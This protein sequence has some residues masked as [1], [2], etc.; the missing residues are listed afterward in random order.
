MKKYTAPSIETTAI[1]RSDILNGS[2]VIIDI[3]TLFG[4]QN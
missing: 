1:T 2:D 4:E 3:E